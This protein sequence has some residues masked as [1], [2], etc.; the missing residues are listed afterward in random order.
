MQL[1]YITKKVKRI[2][3]IGY[4][5][6]YNTQSVSNTTHRGFQKVYDP[7]VMLDNVDKAIAYL[8]DLQNNYPDDVQEWLDSDENLNKVMRVLH[9]AGISTEP[10]V[11]R[12]TLKGED[13]EDGTQ[14]LDKVYQ[15]L[16]YIFTGIKEG[17]LKQS[18]QNGVLVYDDL[19]NEEIR[20]AEVL[21]GIMQRYC[22]CSGK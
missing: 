21:L 8:A 2:N 9:M 18:V 11:V 14:R 17:K 13:L 7:R 15:Q 1:F 3:Y 22:L 10:E 19:L 12:D 4:N 20:E 6:Y 5:W 16:S